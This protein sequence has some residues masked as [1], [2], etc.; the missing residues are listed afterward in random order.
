MPPGQTIS[1][2][3][4]LVR[5]PVY[6]QLND[7]LRELVRSGDFP[8]GAQFLTERQISER[9]EVSRVTAN[10]ALAHL[11]AAGVLEFRPGV[12]TFVR[13]GLLDHDMRSL[14]SFTRQAETLGMRPATRVLSFTRKGF[15]SADPGIRKWFSAG[16]LNSGATG[17]ATGGSPPADLFF[18]ERLR[19]ADRVPVIV[20]RRHV[21]RKF[22]P[23]LT[24]ADLKGSLYTLLSERFG[25][26]VEK[27]EQTIRAVN[28][29]ERD[30]ALLDL[31]SGSAALWLRGRA[32]AGGEV[33]WVEDTYYRG[34]RYQFQNQ[35]TEISGGGPARPVLSRP[36]NSRT[37][38]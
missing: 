29:P 5:Q 37:N 2:P 30:A 27:A 24:K 12:G 21:A 18:F 13:H 28:L 20:E 10:K 35:I 19:L 38:S 15:E 25:I 16:P 6:H 7:L 14:V 11:V 9:F 33:V 8:P 26:V 17:G 23:D 36:D 31:R 34:D 22:C 3:K 1:R 32:L 4:R